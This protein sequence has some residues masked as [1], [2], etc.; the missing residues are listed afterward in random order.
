MLML[1]NICD[2]G[3]TLTQ[4]LW[5]PF[6][7][8]FGPFESELRKRSKVVKDEIKL[9]GAIAAANERTSQAEERKHASMF[10]KEA[11]KDRQEARNRALQYEEQKISK[12][13]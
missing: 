5:R 3:A 13:V 7:K 1:T 4:A 8:E 9:A 11:K 10:R 6:E 12:R 2:V